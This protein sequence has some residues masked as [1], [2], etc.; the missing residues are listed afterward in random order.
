MQ[1]IYPDV[2][3][4]VNFC[5]D[6]IALYLSGIFIHARKNKKQIAISAF[7]GGV[8]SVLMLLLDTKGLIGILLGVCLPVLL[9]Y[10]AYGIEIVGWRFCRLIIIFYV[11]SLLMGG[12]ITAFYNFLYDF[13]RYDRNQ[14]IYEKNRILIFLILS[15]L[16]SALIYFFAHIFNFDASVVKCDISVYFSG[17]SKTFS[18]LVD[19]GNLLRDPFSNA[20]VIIMNISSAENFLPEHMYR[21]FKKWDGEEEICADQNCVSLR[22]IPCN[23]L[24]GKKLLVGYRPDKVEILINKKGKIEKNCVEAIIAFHNDESRFGGMEAIVP[25][26]LIA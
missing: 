25:S 22:F 11:V 19:S 26:S 16:C 23:S 1:I 4:L 6:F 5:M 8:F 9:C 15:L 10:V 17:K 18:A 2:L 24:G 13:F 21:F 3:F 12:A 20:S 7:I 14:I